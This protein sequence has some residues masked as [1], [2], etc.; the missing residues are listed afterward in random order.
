MAS[1]PARETVL[2]PAPR[3][4][5]GNANKPQHHLGNNCC[6]SSKPGKRSRAGTD[7]RAGEVDAPATVD[8][9]TRVPLEGKNDLFCDGEVVMG[10]EKR[11]YR[12]A[13][14]LTVVGMAVYF[15]TTS[16]YM[17][18]NVSP[19]VPIVAGYLA[20]LTFITFFRTAMSDPGILPR[21][22]PPEHD[23]PYAPSTVDSIVRGAEI[24]RKWCN[25]CHFYRPPR[26]VHCFECD[27]CVE[28]YDHH[29]PWTSNCIGRRNYRYYFS[30]LGSLTAF[31]LY[32]IG[33]CVAHVVLV[34]RED[35]ASEIGAKAVPSIIVG[36]IAAIALWPVGGLFVFHC[37][38]ISI[39]KTT[40]ERL[41]NRLRGVKNPYDRGAWSNLLN[42]ICGVRYPRY[43]L[44]HEQSP[45]AASRDAVEMVPIPRTASTLTAVPMEEHRDKSR[46]FSL[47][48]IVNG[49]AATPAEG[50]PHLPRVI[51][52]VLQ[53]AI[54]Q[55]QQMLTTHSER[56]DAR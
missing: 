38:L 7:G 9:V 1:L 34:A 39:G 4:A 3:H 27:N 53:Q 29:C 50:I 49:R 43:V 28:C 30:Y 17:W 37:S 40:N 36:S 13:L 33:S 18:R 44:R 54:P 46:R 22:P 8:G 2:E 25:T 51:I 31:I 10:P 41:T 55:V 16:V 26:T 32:A 21:E 48:S 35:G 23:D 56:E 47:L 5:S 24:K 15:A 45:P 11:L 42:T 52:Q 12:V 6:S 14:G 19:A 20:A